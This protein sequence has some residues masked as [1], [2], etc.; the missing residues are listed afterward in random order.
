MHVRATYDSYIFLVRFYHYNRPISQIPPCIRWISHNTWS[1]SRNKHT[2]TFLL[3]NGALW[4]MGLDAWCIVQG[5]LLITWSIITHH[6]WC[7]TSSMYMVHSD[8]MWQWQLEHIDWMMSSQ[9]ALCTSISWAV[10]IL[11]MGLANERWRYIVTSS[12]IGSTY[13][14]NYICW[15]RYA[16][17]LSGKINCILWWW[18]TT[19]GKTL[20]YLVDFF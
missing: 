14:Q 4:D 10:I 15:A 9:R 19:C 17:K 16:G 7:Q 12:L 2:C 13:T 18:V 20:L 6:V 3:Q 8:I 5:Y 11:S 1:G